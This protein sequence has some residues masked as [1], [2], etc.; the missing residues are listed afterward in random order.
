M[1][2]HGRK[3]QSLG[4]QNSYVSGPIG[5]LEF[6]ADSNSTRDWWESRRWTYNLRLAIAGW[7]AFAAYCLV[8]WTLLPRV[9]P[10][11]DIEITLFTTLF[12][13]IGYL[14]A[15][16]IANLCYLLGPLVET[17]VNPHRPETLPKP[18]TVWE[19]HFRSASPF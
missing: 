16:G 15:M 9:V 3:T 8:C 11:V 4:E 17:I 18:S 13:G 14:I 6:A 19:P 10:A 1:L 5:S 2:V 7:V 12:Q